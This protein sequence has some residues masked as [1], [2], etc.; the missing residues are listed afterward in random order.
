[1]LGEQKSSI[2][3]TKMPKGKSM[4]IRLNLP[5]GAK[6]VEVRADE[7]DGAQIW[8]GQGRDSML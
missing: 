1:M 5:Q 3:Y 8:A 6:N 7:A 4:T 2:H